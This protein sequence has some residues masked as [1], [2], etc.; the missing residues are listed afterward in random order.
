MSDERG[1]PS[2]DY[3]AETIQAYEKYAEHFDRKFALHFEKWVKPYAQAFLALLPGTRVLDL[4]CGPGCHAQYFQKHGLDVLCCDLSPAMV[5]YCRRKGLNASVM[6]M[7]DLGFPPCSFDGIWAY[8]SLLHLPK[9]KIPGVIA[10]LRSMLRQR[11]VIAVSFKQGRTE[12]FEGHEDLP[13]TQRWFSR[14]TAEELIAWFDVGFELLCSASTT[15][16]AKSTF[17]HAVF[18]CT[19]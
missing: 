5:E 2:K 13:G 16:S 17:I 12:G 18:R 10:R 14:V 6:D 7:E 8:A 11:G 1:T 9:A 15:V 4:G 19:I 3:K